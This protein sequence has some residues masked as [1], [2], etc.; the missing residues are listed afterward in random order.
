MSN[1]RERKNR[2][3]R[4]PEE[5]SHGGQERNFYRE[6]FSSWVSAVFQDAQHERLKK[7]WNNTGRRTSVLCRTYIWFCCVTDCST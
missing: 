1:K 3:I 6:P 5:D 4:K 7:S 2:E